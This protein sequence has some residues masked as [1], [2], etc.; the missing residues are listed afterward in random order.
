MSWIIADGMTETG[1]LRHCLRGRC[2]MMIAGLLLTP[3]PLTLAAAQGLDTVQIVDL[4]AGVPALRFVRAVDGGTISMLV[5]DPA[6]LA[7]SQ[8]ALAQAAGRLAVEAGVDQPLLLVITASQPADWPPELLVEQG[9]RVVRLAYPFR[10]KL[11]S[12]EWPGVGPH[13]PVLAVALLP[14]AF[15]LR[16]PLTLHWHEMS[17]EI[18]FRR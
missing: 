3:A 15:T 6:L 1:R 10:L 14:E 11:L 9:G 12:G 18:Q 7:L 17:G 2:L 13:S 5:V 16:G 4:G 8:P